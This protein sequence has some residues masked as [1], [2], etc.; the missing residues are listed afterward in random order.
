MR[1]ISSIEIFS[2]LRELKSLEGLYLKKFYELGDNSFRMNFSSSSASI[3]VYI[4][5]LLAINITDFV[6]NAEEP[7]QFA[8][9]VRKRILGKKLKQI[10][11]HGTDRIIILEFECEEG[12]KL[13]FEMFAK[14]NLVLVDKENKVVLTYRTAKQKDRSVVSKGLYA[15]PEGTTMNFDHLDKEKI[16]A[17]VDEALQSEQRLISALSEKMDIGPLYLEDAIIRSNLDPKAKASTIGAGTLAENLLNIIKNAKSPTPIMYKD[18]EKAVDYAIMQI[19]KYEVYNGEQFESVSKLLDTFYMKE[20][21]KLERDESEIEQISAN[22]ETQRKQ[23]E[24]MQKNE[25]EYTI[26]ANKIFENMVYLN[27]IIDYINQKRRVTLEELQAKFS[28]KVKGVDLKKKSFTIEF[29]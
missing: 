23:I 4:R 10:S 11:Q 24:G 8:I 26:S 20:R 27:S 22:I 5:L 14:G 12:Y 19:K 16:E 25:K 7:T 6:E 29:E 3:S 28:K 21:V 17:I 9:A 1:Q 13:I 2:I 18:G 15:F